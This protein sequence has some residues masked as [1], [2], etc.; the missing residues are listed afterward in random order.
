M[1]RIST[2]G[3]WQSSSNGSRGLDLPGR[4]QYLLAKADALHRSGDERALPIVIRLFERVIAGWPEPAQ[5]RLGAHMAVPWAHL[6]LARIYER[7]AI[8]SVRRRTYG[9]AS[10]RPTRT[11]T[12]SASCLRSF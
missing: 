6:L 1:I 2:S 11:A 5:L 4:A 9:S 10:R 7:G 8:W 3:R 12:G